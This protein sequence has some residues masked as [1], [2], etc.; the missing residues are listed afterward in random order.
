M[1][2]QALTQS[3]GADW[4]IDTPDGFNASFKHGLNRKSAPSLT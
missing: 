2:N 3:V 4:L 1:K